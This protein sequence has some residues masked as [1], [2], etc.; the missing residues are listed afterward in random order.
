[1]FNSS[2]SKVL[3]EA[4][5]PV[6]DFKTCAAGNVNLYFAVDNETMICAGYGGN[7][8]ISGCYGDSG[9]PFV[10]KESGRWVLR[11]AVS[12]GDNQCRAGSTFTVFVRISTFVGWIDASMAKQTCV[13]GKI[14]DSLLKKAFNIVYKRVV[15]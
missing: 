9:G 14:W 2:Y 6:V 11:G 12:W 10:C 1:M 13:P 15:L 3:Q 8:I 5:M 4:K 7:S